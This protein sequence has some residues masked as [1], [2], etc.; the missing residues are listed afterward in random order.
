MLSESLK[1]SKVDAFDLDK[2]KQ[3]LKINELSLEDLKDHLSNFLKIENSDGL[4]GVIGLEIYGNYALLRSFAVHPDYQSNG[5]GKSLMKRL[6][7]K[8]KILDIKEIYLFTTTAEKYFVKY[9]FK[10]IELTEVNPSVKE[11]S[12]FRGSCPKSATIMKKQI[13]M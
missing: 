13:L 3:L 5:I 6:I 1:V 10:K 12:Q 9:G 7:K 2:I 8:S 11:S 4:I